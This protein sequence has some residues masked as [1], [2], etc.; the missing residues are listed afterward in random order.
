[1][2]WGNKNG[3]I[4]SWCCIFTSPN[5]G[6][7][8]HV[9][10]LR[11]SKVQNESYKAEVLDGNFPLSCFSSPSFSHGRRCLV[12]TKICG[13]FQEVVYAFDVLDNYATLNY[14]K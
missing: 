11:N 14:M 5:E 4:T 13:S 6:T 12:V 9:L 2:E 10:F 8:R 7:T 3:K 1:M